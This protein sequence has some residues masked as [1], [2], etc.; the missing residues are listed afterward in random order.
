MNYALPVAI[1]AALTL[2]ACG[3]KSSH[4]TCTDNYT[5]SDYMMKFN[6]DREAAKASGKITKE[7]SDKSEMDSMYFK[8][9]PEDEF[10]SLCNW[11]DAQRKTLGI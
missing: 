4:T 2:S 9:D 6:S 11:A 1:A 5:T 3:S 8:V 7:Q 10:G